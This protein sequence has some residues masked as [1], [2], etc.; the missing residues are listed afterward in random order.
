MPLARLTRITTRSGDAG[1][2]GLAD[3]QRL[4]KDSPR[5]Q[6][7]GD[8]DEL[9]ATLGLVKVYC[10]D[11]EYTRLIAA[12]QQR[13]FDLGGE[14]ALPES[15]MISIDQ[16]RELEQQLDQ[17]NAGLPVLKEF[18]LPGGNPA[19]AHAHLA[20]AI[21]RRA[22]RSLW[23]L[24]HKESVNSESLKY[25]NRLS[26]LLFV[27]ARALARQSSTTEPTWNRET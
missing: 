20:R 11:N 6:A 10:P 2:T 14:L 26:D 8:I 7:L 23:G 27:L 12:I 4:D 3:G 13:L 25:L 24:S 17:I 18:V 21:C 22:E 9:N 5:I 19:A 1:Q 15:T 16:V